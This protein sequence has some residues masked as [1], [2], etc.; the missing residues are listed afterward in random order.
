M[1]VI[2]FVID[3]NGISK[4]EE[5]SHRILNELPNDMPRLVFAN[6]KDSSNTLSISEITEQ[7]E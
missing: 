3:S 6:K 7:L 1:D 2:I 4:A 5:A